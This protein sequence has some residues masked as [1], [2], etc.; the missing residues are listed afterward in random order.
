VGTGS[1]YQAAVLSRLA[2]VVHTVERIPSLLAR[3]KEVLRELGYDNVRAHSASN[4][5]GRPEE[6]PYDVIVV[7]A[8]APHIP[9]SLID[10]LAPEGRLAI[11]VGTLT[12][13]ELVLVRRTTHGIEVRRLGPCG[14]VPLVGKEAWDEHTAPLREG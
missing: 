9:R 7:A 5:L 4:G 6:G 11:P 8:G 1:G 10:Q 14:F 12:G 3:A 2:G 13:Q